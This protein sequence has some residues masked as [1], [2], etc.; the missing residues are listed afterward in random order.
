MNRR[1]STALTS[2]SY[3]P[4]IPCLVRDNIERDLGALEHRKRAVA[5]EARMRSSLELMR[6]MLV[7]VLSA[8][9]RPNIANQPRTRMDS[10]V[11]YL[12]LTPGPFAILVLVFVGLI[13]LIQLQIL[14]YAYMRLGISSGAALFLLWPHWSVA[15]SIFP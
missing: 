8:R 7:A 12:P 3:F 13:I 14:R 10:Q 1:P 4:P 11:H 2:L 15:I 5:Q 6:E 9:P